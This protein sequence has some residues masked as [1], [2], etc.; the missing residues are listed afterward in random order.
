[1]SPYL[2]S[3]IEEKTDG[4]PFTCTKCKKESRRLLRLRWTSVKTG[5]RFLCEFCGWPSAAR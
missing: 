3:K 2:R 5:V 1:M 4:E